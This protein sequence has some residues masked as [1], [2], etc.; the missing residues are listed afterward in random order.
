MKISIVTI[1]FNQEKYLRQCIDS[2]LSQTHCDL[3]YIV[4][5]PGS[6]DGSRALIESYGDRIIKVFELDDGPA[7]GLNRGF[8]RATG[9]IYGFINA[10]D[11]L[12]PSSLQ[13]IDEYFSKKGLQYFVTGQGFTKDAKGTFIKIHPQPL[14]TRDMLHRSA[15]MFQQATFF[16]ARAFQEAGGF[17][18]HNTT[19]WDYELFLR[20]LL[21]DLEHE[22]I[23]EAVAVFRL[24]EESISG[25]GRL[26]ERYLNDLDKIFLEVYG[27]PRAI[28]DRIFTTALR[29]RRE[30]C[31]RLGLRLN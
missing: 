9:Q 18:V 8:K 10:D 14:V 20:F 7:D 30:L 16:P 5:D 12:L 11:Y 31:R 22:V 19:C 23:S 29:I 21:Q 4:V 15:V 17:N 13:H 26:T 27:R 3:E 25:S 6:T 2:I 24:H 28:K 1:S